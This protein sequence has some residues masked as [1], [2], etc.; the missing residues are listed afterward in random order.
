MGD[1]GIGAASLS[2]SLR[3]L[4]E[5]LRT[6]EE[7]LQ[8]IFGRASDRS[9]ATIL[10][11]SRKIFSLLGGIPRGTIVSTLMRQALSSSRGGSS[12]AKMS[13][14]V[15]LPKTLMS[16]LG[17][18]DA[19][20]LETVCREVEALVASV[21]NLR[22][23]ETA[24]SSS[25]AQLRAR[26][27]RFEEALSGLA[28]IQGRSMARMASQSDRAQDVEQLAS[29]RDDHITRLIRDT[30]SQRAELERISR[31]VT[32]INSERAGEAKKPS[33]DPDGMRDRVRAVERQVV[34]LKKLQK[35]GNAGV[36]DTL[37]ALRDKITRLEQRATEMSREAR[38]KTGRLDALSR[39]VSTIEGRLTT[40][41][42]AD[43]SGGAPVVA[44]AASIDQSGE[45]LQP[46]ANS[47]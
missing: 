8:Y 23:R 9:V 24:V 22:E 44:V 30:A 35:S 27:N 3:S 5:A 39:H 19:G 4:I 16:V 43:G 14:N 18:A 25:V 40:A 13:D 10:S 2:Q 6:L 12:D 11:Q 34:D 41:I 17:L 15:N 33:S 37:D 1:T 31:E 26:S 36:I 42:G 21:A 47:N 20:T 7:E 29:R 28:R 46:P 38:A 45:P 32:R